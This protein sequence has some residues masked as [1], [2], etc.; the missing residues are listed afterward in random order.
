MDTL[1]LMAH[2]CL[3][4]FPPAEKKTHGGWATTLTA[5]GVSVVESWLRDLLPTPPVASFSTSL[6]LH[7]L[8][9]EIGKKI[10]LM[11]LNCYKI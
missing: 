11:S 5:F 10:T 6:C 8:L 2:L 1:S 7:F 3:L 9:C 4:V